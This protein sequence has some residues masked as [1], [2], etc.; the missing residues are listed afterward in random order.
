MMKHRFA[1]IFSRDDLYAV[2]S[3]RQLHDLNSYLSLDPTRGMAAK[4]LFIDIDQSMGGEICAPL[5]RLIEQM[6]NLRFI[7][8]KSFISVVRQSSYGT[9]GRSVMKPL[10]ALKDVRVFEVGGFN[11]FDE[12][13]DY[14]DDSLPS[15]SL[16]ES[17]IPLVLV[18]IPRSCLTRQDNADDGKIMDSEFRLM[19]EWRHLHTVRLPWISGVLGSTTTSTTTSHVLPSSMRRL[20]LSTAKFSSKFADKIITCAASLEE[21][22]LGVECGSYH[23]LVPFKSILTSLSPLLLTRFSCILRAPISSTF[24]IPPV[25]DEFLPALLNLYH[26]ALGLEGY[27]DLSRLPPNL[28]SFGLYDNDSNTDGESRTR[29]IDLGGRLAA[30]QLVTVSLYDVGNHAVESNACLMLRKQCE[31]LNIQFITESRVQ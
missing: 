16:F 6:P 24:V 18:M 10:L 17:V 25:L 21:F 8:I 13:T 26:L 14:Q 5:G 28:K 20:E 11:W 4:L 29:V 31:D 9:I 22:H 30:L 19:S 2:K 23:D 1:T 15:E 27:T 3:L 12:V 7:R